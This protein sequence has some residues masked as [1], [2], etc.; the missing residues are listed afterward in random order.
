MA[1]AE[2]VALLEPLLESAG[3]QTLIWPARTVF[4]SMT[5]CWN[6]CAPRIYFGVRVI[7]VKK[8]FYLH[9]LPVEEKQTMDTV[10]RHESTCGIRADERAFM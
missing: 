8:I 9:L 7:D 10:A 3:D 5:Y 1:E 6:L 2:V 4:G